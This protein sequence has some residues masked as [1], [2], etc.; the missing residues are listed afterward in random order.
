MKPCKKGRSPTEDKHNSYVCIFTNSII[1]KLQQINSTQS[2]LLPL[3]PGPVAV[4][5]DNL[6][7][8][9]R[10]VEGGIPGYDPGVAPFSVGQVRR[11]GQGSSL[12]LTHSWHALLVT[13]NYLQKW[14][15]WKI[16]LWADCWVWLI[17]EK[18]Y[19]TCIYLFASCDKLIKLFPKWIENNELINWYKTGT[20]R[21][22][23]NAA[24]SK[25][26]Y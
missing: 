9:N 26:W 7:Y 10:E 22:N 18:N 6:H 11:T 17:N 24:A 5:L 19:S 4:V 2:H 14:R 12:A 8:L 16:W 15:F 25:A 21:W 23:L 1:N 13:L 3:S 20:T